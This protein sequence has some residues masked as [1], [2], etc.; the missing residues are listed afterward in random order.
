MK[1]FTTLGRLLLTL[2]VLALLPATVQ[3]GPP[4]RD[5]LRAR[6]LAFRRYAGM[7]I[8]L[9]QSALAD[10][11]KVCARDMP[12]GIVGYWRVPAK[13]VDVMDAELLVHLRKSG[14]D[15]RLPF[16]PKLYLR[17]YA[18]FVKDGQRFVYVNALLLEKRNPLAEQAKK[19]FPGSCTGIDGYWGIQ[20]DPQA[21]QFVGF[22]SR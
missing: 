14:L 1:S 8:A 20:Y 3:A 10:G 22:N 13:I 2:T 4:T 9:P 7:A 15:K 11:L 6:K 16:S 19:S 5:E 18:G 12:S 17:Q 21:K